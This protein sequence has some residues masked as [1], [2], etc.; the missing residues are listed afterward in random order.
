[1][2]DPCARRLTLVDHMGRSRDQRFKEAVER[3]LGFRLSRR[4]LGIVLDIGLLVALLALPWLVD[5]IRPGFGG[6]IWAAANGCTRF[7]W[8]PQALAYVLLAFAAWGVFINFPRWLRKLWKAA[9]NSG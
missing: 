2:R 4:N 7:C 5:Q 6:Q 1:M 8:T 9:H 3:A